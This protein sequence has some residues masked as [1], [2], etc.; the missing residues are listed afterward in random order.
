M[1]RLVSKKFAP[2][3]VAMAAS[4]LLVA[5]TANAQG[6]LGG[7][8]IREPGANTSPGSGGPAKPKQG[9]MQ[10]IVD[11]NGPGPYKS[12]SHAV[13]DVGEGGVVY[14]MHGTYNESIDLTKSVF[15]QGRSRARFGRRNLRAHEQALPDF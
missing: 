8:P 10:I 2:I 15:I 13:K 11:A 14:V 3:G 7:F 4:A 5:E 1:K 9:P 12:I 6:S